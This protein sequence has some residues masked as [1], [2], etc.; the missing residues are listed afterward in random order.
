M[1]RNERYMAKRV[2]LFFK[3]SKTVLNGPKQQRIYNFQVACAGT[4]GLLFEPETALELDAVRA[5]IPCK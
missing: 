2:H 4:G 1:T 3:S 5:I